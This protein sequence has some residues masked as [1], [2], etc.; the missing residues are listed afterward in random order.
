V[1][2]PDAET[3]AERYAGVDADLALALHLADVADAVTLPR[4]RAADLLVAA[5]A[6]LTPV[7]EADRDAEALVRRVLADQRPLDSVVGEEMGT[8]GG[9][10]RRWI[11]DPVD[12]TKNFVRGIPVWATLVALEQ[13][14]EVVVGVASAPA[15]GR[16]W[17]AARGRGAHADGRPIRVSAVAALDDAQL[18]YSSLSGWDQR[19]G[20]DRLLAL[21]RRCWR[22][23]AFGDFWSHLLVAEGA[24][25]VALDPEVSLWDLA[26]L[27]VIVQEAG[28]T[29]TDLGGRARPDG[30]SAVSTNGRLHTQVLEIL[31]GIGG[32]GSGTG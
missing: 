30:G 12:G 20:V 32:G 7:T 17:W 24:V 26:A 19:G 28:G 13:D 2:H 1:A 23:R 15:L 11:V 25:D 10:A 5:K 16:R 8:T 31:G 22:T 18:S 6:D 27:Q 4:F 21:A 29:F 14:G 3:D 9:G